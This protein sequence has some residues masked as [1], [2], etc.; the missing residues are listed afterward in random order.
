MKLRDQ[1]RE[2]MVV[3]E[4]EKTITK[5]L[6][7]TPAEVKRSFNRIPNDSLPFFSAELEVAQIVKVAKVSAKQK[8]ETKRQLID[9]RNRIADG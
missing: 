5:D 2:Q 1:I 6:T 7:V 9:L 8:E 4:M 3:G